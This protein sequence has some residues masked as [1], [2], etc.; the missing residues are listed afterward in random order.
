MAGMTALQA[1]LKKFEAEAAKMAAMKKDI[2]AS[3]GAG[4][5][6]PPAKRAKKTAGAGARGLLSP[7]SEFIRW[8][9]STVRSMTLTMSSEP[10]ADL[11]RVTH[12]RI[13]DCAR[14]C[15]TS[16]S[17]GF[18]ACCP[19]GVS[20]EPQLSHVVNSSTI[21]QLASVQ[22]HGAFNA[23]IRHMSMVAN[24]ARRPIEE[25]ALLPGRK[26]CLMSPDAYLLVGAAAEAAT[27][28]SARPA[29][30]APIGKSIKDVID[31][32][33]ASGQ[34]ETV[35]ST[36]CQRTTLLTPDGMPVTIDMWW[37]GYRSFQQLSEKSM[38]TSGPCD[39]PPQL[40]V[41]HFVQ[42]EMTPPSLL[43]SLY[44]G[45]SH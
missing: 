9:P 25:L 10:H 45:T 17:Y 15:A 38:F 21:R 1:T 32:L 42:P 7:P 31:H 34:P 41:L 18:P 33:R 3:R 13:I 43:W 29:V 27:A 2:A 23:Y 36:R 28:R 14:Q 16:C 20:S 22:K 12:R 37:V 24:G 30:K 8:L 39:V 4:G 26:L 5:K 35:R 44:I 40:G 6:P 11:L 19:R